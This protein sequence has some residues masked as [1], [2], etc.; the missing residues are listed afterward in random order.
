MHDYFGVCAHVSL[1]QWICVENNSESTTL[2]VA[3]ACV[4]CC[5]CWCVQTGESQPLRVHRLDWLASSEMLRVNRWFD[6]P[7]FEGEDD[8]RAETQKTRRDTFIFGIYVRRAKDTKC[9]VHLSIKGRRLL[10]LPVV[11]HRVKKTHEQAQGKNARVQMREEKAGKTMA[12]LS[13]S[14]RR[15]EKTLR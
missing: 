15:A 2:F 11:S 10:R 5:C 13:Q 7:H 12:L 4:F 1:W 14:I 9:D 8:E 6:K 3:V